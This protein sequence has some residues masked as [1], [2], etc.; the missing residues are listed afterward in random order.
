MKNS[1]NHR[2]RHTTPWAAVFFL[3]L[4]LPGAALRAQ[5]ISNNGAVVTISSGLVVSAGSLE[6]S[7]GTVTDNGTLTLS[8]SATNAGTLDG[9]GAWNVG[10]NWANNG[11]FTPGTS[12]VKM[13]GGAAQTIGGSVACVFYNLDIA[14]TSG[15]VS[16][17]KD[18]S[19]SNMLTLTSGILTTDATNILSVTNTAVSAV[20]AGSTTKFVSGPLKWSLGV[21]TYLFPVGKSA[22]SYLPF[23][24][25]TSAASAP[26]VTVEAYDTDAGGGATFDGTLTSIS[27]T[28]YWRAVLNSGTFTGKVSLTRQAVL[29][30]EDAIGKSAAQGGSYT[31]VGGT[32][33]SPSVVNSDDMSSFSYFVMATARRKC[34]ASTAVAPTADQAG[35]QGFTT[36][37]LTATITNSLGRGTPTWQY[38]WY[39]NPTGV[40]TV[41]GATAIGA[42]SSMFTPLSGMAEAGPARHYF[43]VGY[44]TDNGCAQTS[45]TQA[46][47]SAEVVK[48]TV[49][50][51]PIAKTCKTDD[52]CQLNAGTVKVEFS[53]GTPPYTIAWTPAHGTPASPQAFGSAG[54]VTITG[55]HGGQGYVFTVTDDNGCQAQ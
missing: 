6:N 30:T 38:Q 48:V 32:A 47:A 11:T 29:T 9:N 21:G 34:P 4:V 28:E 44:A 42:N 51:L 14:N 5:V 13:N 31:D 16:L 7:S 43:C 35:C 23:T 22:S 10:G 55:L 12:T 20:S 18:E 3:A 46:L 37:P 50:P 45:T 39:Y 24:L 52:L 53:S 49:Y 54:D 26:V 36:N 33:S 40:N 41:A 17:T 2:P 19:V 25:A 1:T 27:H 15:G 8:G